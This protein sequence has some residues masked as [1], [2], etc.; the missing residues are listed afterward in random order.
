[1]LLLLLLLFLL[2]LSYN[3]L[4]LFSLLLDVVVIVIVIRDCLFENHDKFALAIAL[5]FLLGSNLCER[6][7]DAC[8][9]IL[10]IAL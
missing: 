6:L 10:Y 8:I 1:M 5:F 2:V 9:F 3:K 7:Y 4:I